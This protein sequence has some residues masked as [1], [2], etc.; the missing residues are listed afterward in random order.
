VKISDNSWQKFLVPK[1]REKQNALKYIVLTTF[2]TNKILHMKA[3]KNYNSSLIFLAIFSVVMVSI[4]YFLTSA[5]RKLP[6]YNPVD[7]NPRLVDSKVK[8]ISYGHK[9]ADFNLIN[10]N[11]ETITQNDYQDKIY[12]AEFFFT[13]CKTICPIMATNMLTLQD[14]FLK[15]NDVKFLS[16]SVTPIMDSV[17]IL[18]KYAIK[19]GII[20]EKWNITTGNKQHIYELARKSYMAVLDE[21]D[22][23]EQDFI[24]TEQFVLIDK[25]RQIRGF[26]DGT[27]KKDIQ[28]II[29]DINLLKKEK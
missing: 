24:H 5:E 23:D 16:M 3:K 18:K 26:Y 15:D 13:R 28:Q 2:K 27:S 17:P 22:G 9:I 20:T 7:I 25:Q 12:V 14:E 8:H 29:E 21:G 10:Q 11:G 6:V 4:I 1:H 19:K